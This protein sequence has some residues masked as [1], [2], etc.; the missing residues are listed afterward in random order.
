MTER[1]QDLAVKVSLPED[2]YLQQDDEILD[3]FVEEL[4]EIF[5]ELNRLLPLWMV[6]RENENYLKDIR[7]HFH[8]LKGSG[9]MVGANSAGEL[10]WHVEDLLNRTIAKTVELSSVLQ[11]FVCVCKNIFEFKLYPSFEQHVALNIN[12][13]PL[14]LLSKKLQQQQDIHPNFIRLMDELLQLNGNHDTS[15]DLHHGAHAATFDLD[16]MVQSENDSIVISTQAAEQISADHPATLD[17]ELSTDTLSIYLEEGHEHLAAINSFLQ[18]SEHTAKQSDA[19]IR[20]L[21]TLKGS[22]GMAHIEPLF[23]ASTN[24]EH[25]LKLHLQENKN[26]TDAETHLLSDF[27]SYV[28]AYLGGLKDANSVVLSE[29]TDQFAQVWLNYSLEQGDVTAEKISGT[30]SEI[31]ELQIDHLLDAEYDFEQRVREHDVAYLQQLFNEANLLFQHT[32][33]VT[34]RTLHTVAEKLMLAYQ[35]LIDQP[36]LANDSYSYELFDLAHQQLIAC[37]DTLATGQTIH[38]SEKDLALFDKLVDWIDPQ[39]AVVADVLDTPETILVSPEGLVQACQIAIAQDSQLFEQQALALEDDEVIDIFVDEADDLIAELEQAFAAYQSHPSQRELLQPVMRCLHT[40]KGGANMIAAQ[41]IAEMTHVLE[42]IYE[43]LI[44]RQQPLTET[45]C[46]VLV[47]VQ[48]N[49]SSR[50]DLVRHQHKDYPARN[51]LAVLAEMTSVSSDV[52]HAVDTVSP[53]DVHVEQNAQ[54]VNNVLVANEILADTNNEYI[55]R[56]LADQN[57]A[58]TQKTQLEDIELAAIFVDEAAD[59]LAQI[60]Q[61]FA[62]YQNTQNVDALKSLMRALHTLKGGANMLQAYNIGHITHALESV[63]EK[64]IYSQLSVTQSLLAALQCVQDQLSTRLELIQNQAVDYPATG[65]LAVL[66]ELQA[67]VPDTKVEPDTSVDAVEHVTAS[68]EQVLTVAA[69]P[70]PD[71]ETSI[72]QIIYQQFVE[73]AQ[74]LLAKMRTQLRRWFDHRT[75]RGLLLQLQRDAHTIKGAA[76]M[77]EQQHIAD[78][79]G[80]LDSVFEQFALRQF[81]SNVYD[82]LLLNALQ[83]LDQAVAT[84]ET[85]TFSQLFEQLNTIDFVGVSTLLDST[86]DDRATLTTYAV[87]E[88]DGTEP[89]SMHGEWQD[90]VAQDQTPEMIRVS[91]G[92]VEKMIDLAGENAIN[93][94]RIEMDMSQFSTTLNEMELAIQ[95]LSDQL[96]RMEGELESQIIAKHGD[97]QSRYKDFDPLEMDQYSSLNQLSKSLAESASD[98]IDFKVTLAEKV[99]DTEGLLLQQSRIQAEMQDDLMRIRLVPFSRITTRLQRLV[100]QISSSLNRPV[101]FEINNRDLELDRSILERLVTPLEH[102]LRNAIDHGI[103]TA[104]LRL[105]A[106]KSETGLI[107]ISVA[108][109]GT[110]IVID[111][112]DDGH[113]IDPRHIEKKAQQLGLLSA[114]HQLTDQEILQYIFHSGLS[115]AQTVTQIS[116]RGVGLDIVK[117]DIKALG[118]NITI[119]SRI[120]EGTH[121]NIRVPTT[122]SVSD[123]LMVKVADQQYAIPLAQIERIVRVSPVALNEY[124]HS[125]DEHFGLDGQRYKLRYASEFIG[126]FSAQP[127]FMQSGYSL[128]VLLIKGNNNETV[129]LLVDQLIGSRAQIVVKPLGQQL[130]GIDVIGGATILGDG[131]VCL[132]LDTTN[133]ARRIQTQSRR[134]DNVRTETAKVQRARQCIMIVDDSV[135]VRKVTTR[136][137]ERQGYDVV[138]AKDGMDAIEQIEH[139][140]PDLMLLDIEMPRMDGFEVTNIL[141]HHVVY[142]DLPII[143]ITS[144]TGEKHR[145]RAFS[146]GVTQYMGKPFQE[147]DLLAN[148]EQVLA[149]QEV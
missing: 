72:D 36:Q 46:Q 24:V 91:A 4:Q 92:L 67:Q 39:N 25:A 83:W 113:G 87:V 104:D 111:M 31:V 118:G 121:F 45:L 78:V 70:Q 23:L 48:D 127:R 133:L 16:D 41:N 17:S 26:L 102:M 80:K 95:R 116:G 94:S 117:N 105:H 125:D 47:L 73:E 100:R 147:T 79:A 132:I 101:H 74:G 63:Y 123:A 53:V 88:G 49:L 15:L 61:T 13:H 141:R 7:R 14:L 85:D 8:T 86:L 108:R 97:E 90:E 50:L 27:S 142:H 109:Q 143:M 28:S 33:Q 135:T 10:A 76:R 1:L 96:R 149:K 6:E 18:F 2:T 107:S 98:L 114:Q 58:L 138:T 9:R 60:D 84:A 139:I 37:F 71:S 5:V 93:R 75:D 38:L 89:P 35:G 64:V 12:L 62:D 120:G 3:I 57:F 81:S 42:S 119:H 40:L 110:D 22:S 126:H 134:S 19:L 146:L 65:T 130:S 82:A 103:E 115:T 122:V 69:E 77:A 29:S 144:R 52:T 59:L 66:A 11:Q 136:L 68:P 99:R 51:L 129:A 112:R 55:Q 44:H 30:V 20:A 128:P 140:K 43:H 21:H 148:I 54:L 56:I 137:L 131:Q 145:E 34:T 124:F 32:Q 106:N